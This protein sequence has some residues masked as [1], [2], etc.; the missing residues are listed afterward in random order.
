VVNAIALAYYWQAQ[1]VKIRS[2]NRS[3]R[4]GSAINRLIFPFIALVTII[5]PIGVP[6]YW[7][8]VE[9]IFMRIP[10]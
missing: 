10:L 1:G 6:V 9:K 2:F 7:V 3:G 8:A 5:L 4:V